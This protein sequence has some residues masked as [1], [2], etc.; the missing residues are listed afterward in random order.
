MYALSADIL[1]CSAQGAA[2]L[3]FRH[4]SEADELAVLELTITIPIYDI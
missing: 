4:S 3:I 2:Q 1:S